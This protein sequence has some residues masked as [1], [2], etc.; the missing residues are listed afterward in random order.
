MYNN[1]RIILELENHAKTLSVPFEVKIDKAE[2]VNIPTNNEN[3]KLTTAQN[4][5]I[6]IKD[7]LEDEELKL[8]SKI[9]KHFPAEPLEHI[10]RPDESRGPLHRHDKF[11][12]VFMF[13][14]GTE[15]EH[16]TINKTK[17]AKDETMDGVVER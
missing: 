14:E 5:N 10:R 11:C 4:I 9:S 12:E 8:L 3:N 17:P 6:N 2:L 15:D 16:I 1:K 13:P 7:D